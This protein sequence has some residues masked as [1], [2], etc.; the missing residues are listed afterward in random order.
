MFKSLSFVAALFAYAQANQVMHKRMQAEDGAITVDP[1]DVVDLAE[2]GSIT[3]DPTA[4]TTVDDPLAGLDDITGDLD[5]ALAGLDDALAG[6]DGLDDIT[7]DLDDITGGL[8]DVL[9]LEGQLAEAWKETCLS[10]EVDGVWIDA[11]DDDGAHCLV[12]EGSDVL[13]PDS[14]CWDTLGGTSGLGGCA[15]VELCDANEPAPEIGDV[16]DTM[17]GEAQME[18]T[19]LSDTVNGVWIASTDDTA[20]SCLIY[21]G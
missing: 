12:Y 14:G 16:L 3:V 6:L 5:D 13:C 9:D 1:A 17:F 7:G 18:L 19:C 15:S 8:D 10:D 4:I 20:A 11:T 21:E 2:D